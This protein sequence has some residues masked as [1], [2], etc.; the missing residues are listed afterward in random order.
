DDVSHYA[1]PARATDLAGLPPTYISAQEFDPLR[2]E[3]LDYGARL[4]EAGVSVEVH[5]FPGTFH[6]ST[7]VAAAAVSK[8]QLDEQY[9]VLRR[10]LGG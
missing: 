8:R 2:D 9:A 7:A 3:A 4:L 6:G 10:H 5:H 1:A